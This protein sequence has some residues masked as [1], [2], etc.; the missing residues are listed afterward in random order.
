MLGKAQGYLAELK[1]KGR[2]NGL[3][4]GNSFANGFR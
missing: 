2:T 3:E 1:A 4:N